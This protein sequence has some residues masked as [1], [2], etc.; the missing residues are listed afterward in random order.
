MQRLKPGN[1]DDSRTPLELISR[2]DWVRFQRFLF[3]MISNVGVGGR[4]SVLGSGFGTIE[5]C[6]RDGKERRRYEGRTYQ[7]YGWGLRGDCGL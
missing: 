7:G 5:L 2:D 1:Y 3:E 4:G 6:A